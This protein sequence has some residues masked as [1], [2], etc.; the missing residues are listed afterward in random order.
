MAVI[1]LHSDRLDKAEF[2]ALLRQFGSPSEKRG[3]HQLVAQ[4]RPVGCCD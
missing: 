1:D 3:A 4:V 2:R